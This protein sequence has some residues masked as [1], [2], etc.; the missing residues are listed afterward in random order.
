[1][2]KKD[3]KKNRVGM[4]C[5][6]LVVGL[7]LIAG[8]R[9]LFTVCPRTDHIMKCWWSVQAVLGLGIIIIFAGILYFVFSNLEVKKVITFMAIIVFIVSFLI[10]RVLIGGCMNPAMQCQAVTFPWI[11]GICAVSILVNLGNVVYLYRIGGR[12]NA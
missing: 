11:Y 7:L 5:Y 8:P 1:M 2:E 10:P 9:S 12:E 3:F 4:G 6:N